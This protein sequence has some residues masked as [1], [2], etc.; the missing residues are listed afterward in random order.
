MSKRG[1]FRKFSILELF[2]DGCLLLCFIAQTFVLGCILIYGYLPLPTKLLSEKIT[3]Q[4]PEGIS[5]T[6]E[7]YALKLDGTIQMENIELKLDHISQPVFKTE[8]A[9]AEISVHKSLDAPFSLKEFVLSNGTLMIPAVYSPSGEDSPI[10]EHIALRLVPADGGINI[11]S[12]AA[13]HEEIRLRGSLKWASS[14]QE[15]KPID[16]Q[17]AADA[18]FKQVSNLLKQKSRFEGL[19]RPTILFQISGGKDAPL[20]IVGKVSSRS[21]KNSN[22]L[23]EN[24]TLDATLSLTGQT[25]VTNSS[26]LFEADSVELQKYNTRASYVKARLER[27]EWEALL[28]GEWPDMEV[29]ADKLKIEGIELESPR[30]NFRPEAFPEIAFD[31]LTKGLRGVVDFSGSVNASTRA[32]K[33][34]A[35]GSIDLMSIAP[36]AITEQ[37]PKVKFQRAPYYNLDLNFTEGF[38]LEE[39][40]LRARMDA[41]EV[42]GLR[43]DHVRFRGGYRDGVYTIDH[44]YLRRDWQWLDLGFSLD[45]STDKYAVTLHGFA[46]PDDYNAIL[47]RWWGGIFRDFDFEEIESGLGDFVIYGNTQAKAADFFF[48]HARARNVAFQGVR[49]DEGEL[50]VRGKGP[51]A[52]VYKLNVRR[53]EGFARGN[54]RFASRLDEVHGPMSVRLNLDTKL[55]LSD[56]KKLFDED[57]AKVLSDFK[58]DAMPRTILKGAIFNKSYPEFKGLSYIDLSATCPFP[59]SYKGIPLDYLSFDLYGRVGVTHLRDIQFGYADGEARAAA[60]ILTSGDEPAQMRFDMSLKGADQTRA[61]KQ[62]TTLNKGNADVTA[63]AKAENKGTLDLELAALGPVEDPFAMSGYGNLKIENDQLYAIQLFGPLSRLLQKVRL[64][65]TSFELNELKAQFALKDGTAEFKQLQI[66]GPRTRIDA[67][68]TLRLSDFSLAMRVSVYLFGNAG[69]PDSNIRKISNLITKPIPNLLE[70]DLSGT[71]EEQQWRSIY[72]PRNLIPIF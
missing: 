51:Y 2:F 10:L 44:L 37:I 20:D 9:H 3:D 65:F 54:I 57:I 36:E 68:G 62:L 5:I 16:A 25:L 1:K 34:S 12:F 7:S 47:P 58:T 46:K 72:D 69:S 33:V 13:L 40:T 49:I 32:A 15:P 52:E 31:G 53:G 45:S 71:A 50:F 26:I 4:L 43:F 70:F 14:D 63:E 59:L 42:E 30:I 61:I 6:A 28:Q 67:P 39:A 22:I 11:D 19:T 29:V 21:Y 35:S 27:D 8:S 48:G 56:A 66:N 18:F 17:K 38:T 60:D 23:A 41:L 24:L 64:G 55:P